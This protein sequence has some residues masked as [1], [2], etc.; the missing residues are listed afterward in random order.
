[1]VKCSNESYIDKREEP[2]GEEEE[3]EEE[4]DVKW[5]MTSRQI[6]GTSSEQ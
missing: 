5:V 2:P 6:E 1:M 3:E 4:E